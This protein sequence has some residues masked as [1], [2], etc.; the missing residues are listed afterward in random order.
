[1]YFFRTLFTGST[2]KPEPTII[3]GMTSLYLDSERKN[4]LYISIEEKTTC[5]DLLKCQAN[6]T[7]I[8]SKLASL[9]GDANTENYDLVLYNPSNPYSQ[10]KL[11]KKCRPYK[12][13]NETNSVLILLNKANKPKRVSMYY[14]DNNS[15]VY[16]RKKENLKYEFVYSGEMQKFSEKKKKFT[17]KKCGITDCEFI[18]TS[19]KKQPMVK[20][21]DIDK[22]NYQLTKASSHIK[23]SDQENDNIIEIVLKSGKLFYLFRVKRNSDYQNWQNQ[24]DYMLLK[25]NA[26][27]LDETFNT[28]ISANISKLNDIYNNILEH[29]YSVRGI[30][31]IDDIRNMFFNLFP[32]KLFT[33]IIQCIIEYKYNQYHYKF[34]EQWAQFKMMLSHLKIDSISNG[35]ATEIENKLSAVISLDKLSEIRTLAQEI[36]TMVRNGV[37]F[38]TISKEKLKYDLFDELYENIIDKILS[39]IYDK[40][41]TFCNIESNKRKN[42]V[43]TTS[44]VKAENI[45]EIKSSDSSNKSIEKIMSHYYIKNINFTSKSFLDLKK[46]INNAMNNS[47]QN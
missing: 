20:I 18:I 32:E 39:P 22:I 30:I 19:S 4:L 40:N 45:S 12:M 29:C 46:E 10:Q 2:P 1:M 24:F 47:E 17:K 36:N 15:N 21:K 44:K 23:L 14:N 42:V 43:N 8:E 28:S 26:L 41:F 7:K 16:R 31:Q 34:I 13:I 35:N 9:Y 33:D 25:R 5:E 6:K 37:D 3:N 38:N 11:D 27:M